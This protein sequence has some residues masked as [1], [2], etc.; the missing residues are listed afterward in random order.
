MLKGPVVNPADFSSSGN[1]LLLASC[2]VMMSSLKEIWI[3]FFAECVDDNVNNDVKFVMSLNTPLMVHPSTKWSLKVTT[4]CY[5]KLHR[6]GMA[7]WLS[8]D[9]LLMLLKLVPSSPGVIMSRWWCQQGYLAKTALWSQK[10]TFHS[11]ACPLCDVIRCLF[12][13]KSFKSDHFWKPLRRCL[14]ILRCM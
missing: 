12:C 14:K 13:W 6:T 5:V 1:W 7:Y 9:G 10:V 11:W 4:L 3:V 8:S 2:L